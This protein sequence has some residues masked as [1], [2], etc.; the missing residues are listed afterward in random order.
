MGNWNSLCSEQSCCSVS[1]LTDNLTQAQNLTCKIRPLNCE[2]PPFS[3]LSLFPPLTPPPTVCDLIWIIRHW[4]LTL[5]ASLW[6]R[7]SHVMVTASLLL[8]LS[9]SR[10]YPCWPTWRRLRTRSPRHSDSPTYPDAQLLTWS[11]STSPTPFGRDRAGGGE[12]TDF[13]ASFIY[14]FPL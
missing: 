9:C 1:A 10:R 6:R 12:V 7:W 14:S 5:L 8:S 3:F 2:W 11:S 4:N 13:W